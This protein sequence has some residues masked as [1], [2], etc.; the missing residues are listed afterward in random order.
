MPVVAKVRSVLAL[1][2]V[3]AGGEVQATVCDE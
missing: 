2:Q 3:A 1:R